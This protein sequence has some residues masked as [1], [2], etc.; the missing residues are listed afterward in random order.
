MCLIP[1]SISEVVWS[2][3]DSF[4]SSDRA[5]CSVQVLPVAKKESD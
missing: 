3:H 4:N 2:L 1:G 5:S